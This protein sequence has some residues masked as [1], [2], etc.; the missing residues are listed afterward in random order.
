MCSYIAV[1]A[2]TAL[3]VS[4]F[5][6]SQYVGPPYHGPTL[7]DQPYQPHPTTANDPGTFCNGQDL[8][9]GYDPDTLQIP[10]DIYAPREIDIPFHR[11][12]YGQAN[13]YKTTNKPDTD[14][15]I[16][17]A[18]YDN[19]NQTA[20]G[21]PTNSYWGQQVAIHPYFLKY[22]PLDRKI[23]PDLHHIFANEGR[24]VHARCVYLGLA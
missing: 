22:A 16:W 4:Q 14:S 12:F 5:A 11:V 20:C 13:F 10:P 21:I 6:S 17:G 3:A 19:A 2:I 15:G 7:T 23:L 18:E 1:T 8:L 24:L 9:V